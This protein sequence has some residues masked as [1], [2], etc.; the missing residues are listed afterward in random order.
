MIEGKESQAAERLARRQ[1]ARASRLLSDGL[2]RLREG[3]APTKAQLPFVQQW[4]LSQDNQIQALKEVAD[5][6]RAGKAYAEW[7]YRRLVPE[8]NSVIDV[9]REFG[10]EFYEKADEGRQWD[11]KVGDEIVEHREGYGSL[12]EALR[13]ALEWRI[14]QG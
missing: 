8:W 3:K 6:E 2:A 4:L 5:S 9:L 11:G 7:L 1:A 13:A 12:A 14:K 10:L